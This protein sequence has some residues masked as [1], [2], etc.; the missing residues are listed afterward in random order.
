MCWCNSTRDG[1]EATS[2]F[3]TCADNSE[4]I[5]E[6]DSKTYELLLRKRRAPKQT[7]GL[8]AWEYLHG[9][10]AAG[11]QAQSCALR[12]SSLNVRCAHSCII[13]AHLALCFVTRVQSVCR[14]A[15]LST[16]CERK[17]ARPF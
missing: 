5:E 2:Y 16:T 10:D 13:V 8:S 6:Y 1:A 11:S 4:L 9:E 12:E 15:S 17:Y 14:S 3:L 7:G